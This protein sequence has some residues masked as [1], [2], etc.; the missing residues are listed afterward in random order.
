MNKHCSEIQIKNKSGTVGTHIN[1]T[2]KVE[3]NKK[4]ERRTQDHDKAYECENL[5]ANYTLTVTTIIQIMT[6]LYQ[7]Y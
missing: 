6:L 3:N 4:N 5:K 7:Y 2:V 1:S